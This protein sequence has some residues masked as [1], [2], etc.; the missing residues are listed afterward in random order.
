MDVASSDQ[1]TVKPWFTGKLDMAP[2]VGDFAEQGFTLVGGRLD[3]LAGRAVPALVYRHNEH[4]INMFM[5][6]DETGDD[7]RRS[8]EL[9][10]YA[11]LTWKKAGL[12]YWA[13]C[14]MTPVELEKLASLVDGAGRTVAA[15]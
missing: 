5:L 9:R 1:H 4:I 2:P 3:Y 15:E 13:V 6:P 11:L 8:M 14:D 12:A 10:G 7:R